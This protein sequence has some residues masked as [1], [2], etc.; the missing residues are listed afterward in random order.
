MVFKPVGV[1]IVIVDVVN[2]LGMVAL[3]AQ[4]Q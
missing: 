2:E 3:E 1:L 4:S